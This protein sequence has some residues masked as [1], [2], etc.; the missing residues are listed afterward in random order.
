MISRAALLWISLLFPVALA[1]PLS[2][3]IFDSG[4]TS[5]STPTAISKDT[6]QA[7]FL[8]PAQFSRVAYCSSEAVTSWTCGAPCES[9][10]GGVKV[11][12]AGGDDGLIPMYFVAHDP[13]TESI[14]VAHQGT[15]KSSVL[16]ILNDVQIQLV[17]LNSTRFP[18]ANEDI[19]VHDGFQ[20]TFERT[21]DGMLEAVRTGLES[22]GTNKVLVTGH[23][24]GAAVATLDA[25]F[26]KQNLEPSV[27]VT[28][29]LFGLPRG[30]NQE[31]ADFVD[32]KLGSTFTHISNQNDPV[33][34]VPPRFLGYQHPAGEVHIKAVDADG[35]ATDIVACG[36]QE[37]E[38]CS[39]G[40][41]VLNVSIDNHAGPYL[42]NISF[43]G[44]FCPL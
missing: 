28:T 16:S 4:S 19:K 31:W 17:G 3:N 1:A 29:T 36:G 20:K 22:T 41:S 12:Q 5:T 37:N 25:V 21:A 18:D 32:S 33:P 39:E 9:L 35:E 10:G 14:I 42:G 13:A 44:K 26:L 15:E 6:V 7:Q 38:N 11:L 24:L 40:N 43:G 27:E 2:L 8:R 34:T 30:G 23:S